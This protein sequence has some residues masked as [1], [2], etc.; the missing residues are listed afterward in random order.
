MRSR[1]GASRYAPA[2]IVFWRYVWLHAIIG[3]MVAGT[4]GL[5]SALAGRGGIALRLM[6]IAIVTKRGTV[7]SGKRARLR[8]A[9]SWLPVLAAAAATFAGH[10]PLMTLSQQGTS[11]GLAVMFLP[12][13]FFQNEPS[14]LFVRVAIITVAVAV[15]A[16]G[17][18]STVI[19]PERGLQ[20]CLAGTWL[21]PR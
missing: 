11:R 19:R 5:I 9:L 4:V 7:A 8:S 13:I 16:L 6:N 12:P 15:L 10:S 18:I 2:G 20:D 3:L 21:V 1:S 17:A 14:I